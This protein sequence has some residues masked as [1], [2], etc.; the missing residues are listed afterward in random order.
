MII[1]NDCSINR[2][3]Q[4]ITNGLVL[5]ADAGAYSGDAKDSKRQKLA[6]RDKRRMTM[7]AQSFTI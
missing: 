1:P 4:S 3:R 7:T 6:Y 2:R 5:L